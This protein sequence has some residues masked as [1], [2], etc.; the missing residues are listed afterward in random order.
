V[1]HHVARLD[2]GEQQGGDGR[3]AGREGQRVLRVFPQAEAVF[4]DLLVR[5]VEARIDETFR[6]AGPL[7]GDALEMALAGGR[8]LEDEGRGEEDRAASARLPTASD[9]SRGPSSA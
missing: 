7:A 4:E 6:A 9:R 5:A 8:V 1:H 2:E 3:H